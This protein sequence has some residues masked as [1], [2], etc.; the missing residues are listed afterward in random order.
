MPKTS[1]ERLRAFR[2]GQHTQK[3]AKKTPK[4]GL[5]RLR[6]FRTKQRVLK[7]GVA[8]NSVLPAAQSSTIDNVDNTAN[9]ST[10]NDA[11]TGAERTLT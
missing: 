7:S 6:E 3:P 10:S 5:Q 2:K 9:P 11:S 8:W 4:S 1:T